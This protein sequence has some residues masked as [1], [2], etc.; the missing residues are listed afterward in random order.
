MALYS[1]SCPIDGEFDTME[2]ADFAICPKCGG[3]ARRLWRLRINAESARH[4][5]HFDPI[6]GAYVESERQFDS[7]LAQGRDKQAEKLGMDVKLQKVDA[8][9]GEALAELH[10]IPKDVRDADTEITKRAAYDKKS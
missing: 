7:L 1:Y 5:G 2:R 8:R 9:D 4:R 3:V 10:G 6:V